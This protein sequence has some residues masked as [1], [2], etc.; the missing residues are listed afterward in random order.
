MSDDEYG[1]L[2]AIVSELGRNPIYFTD[3][4]LTPICVFCQVRGPLNIPQHLPICIYRRAVEF[5][6][7]HG[8]GDS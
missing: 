6:L 1:E 7:R 4:D 2:A 8:N 5:R 3:Y